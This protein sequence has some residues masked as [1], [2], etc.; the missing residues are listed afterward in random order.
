MSRGTAELVN[1][2]AVIF[3]PD[4]FAKVTVDDA[5]T[6]TLT[7]VGEWLQLYVVEKSTSYIVVGEATGQDGTFDYLVQGVRSGYE[8]WQVVRDRPEGVGAEPAGVGVEPAR[9]Q[10]PPL[11]PADRPALERVPMPSPPTE[12]TKPST[13]EE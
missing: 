3:L 11:W 10:Q 1:G 5:L 6:V 2:E 12:R 9:A 7:P 4:H 8:D 13:E